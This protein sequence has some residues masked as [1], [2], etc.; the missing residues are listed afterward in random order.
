[1]TAA[2]PPPHDVCVRVTRPSSGCGG[3]I[4]DADGSSQRSQARGRGRM[5]KCLRLPSS[6]PDRGFIGAC[7]AERTPARPARVHPTVGTEGKSHD[8]NRHR[9]P[10]G[11]PRRLRGRRS[12]TSDQGGNVRQRPTGPCG[13]H[14]L[15]SRDRFRRDD[16]HRGLVLRS[17]DRWRGQSS[18]L[19]WPYARYRRTSAAP[20]ADAPADRA[21]AIRATPLRSPG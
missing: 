17:A 13:V 20:S 15:G 21:R 19:G 1:M 10:Q 18:T 6:G 14:R 12:R 4:R 5:T 7:P 2:V 11:D 3:S 16:R 8:G 9:H